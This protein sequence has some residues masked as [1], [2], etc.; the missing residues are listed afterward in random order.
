MTQRVTVVGWGCQE[1]TAVQTGVMKG[2]CSLLLSGKVF[3]CF[4]ELQ[5]YLVNEASFGEFLADAL[6]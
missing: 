4:G 2:S 5:V 3:A 6:F 1:E